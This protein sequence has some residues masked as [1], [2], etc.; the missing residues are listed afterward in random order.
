MLIRH[1][2]LHIYQDDSYYFVSVHTFGDVPVLQ[3][4]KRKNLLLKL[5]TKEF[6]KYQYKLFAFIVLDNHYHL[7]FQSCRGLDLRDIFHQLHGS[8]SHLLNR[9]DGTPGR[10][11]FQNYWDYIL[12]NEIDFYTHFNYIHNNPIKHG[13]LSHPADLPKYHSSSYNF[14]IKKKGAEW[15]NQCWERYPIRDFSVAPD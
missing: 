8:L 13:Y 15:I 7:L 10:K 14:W 11:I 3:E 6:K 1:Q 12:R 4:S 2:P 9:E 5:I